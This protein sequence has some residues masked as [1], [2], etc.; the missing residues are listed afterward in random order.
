MFFRLQKW[1]DIILLDKLNKHDKFMWFLMENIDGW[2]ANTNRIEFQGGKVQ[3][4]KLYGVKYK[5]HQT[6]Q[7]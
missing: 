4:L 6:L 7:E 1:Y 3:I 5:H 2:V